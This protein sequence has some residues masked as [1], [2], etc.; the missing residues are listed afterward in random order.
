MV[1]YAK[2]AFVIG[3]NNPN[4]EKNA[5]LASKLHQALEIKYPGI[6]KRVMKHDGSGNNGV[7][8]QDLSVRLC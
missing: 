3:G 5:A 6:F 4:F 1:K 8:N 7:Y 2:I